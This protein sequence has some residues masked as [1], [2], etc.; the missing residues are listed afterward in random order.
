MVCVFALATTGLA[1][2]NGIISPS[3][4]VAI[5]KERGEGKVLRTELVRPA[6][7]PPYYVVKILTKANEVRIIRVDA[8]ENSGH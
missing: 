5:A 1:Q 4:A 6:K 8:R 7:G 2:E 3:Q